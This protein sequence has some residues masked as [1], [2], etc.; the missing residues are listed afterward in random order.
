[1]VYKCF[2]DTERRHPKLDLVRDFVDPKAEEVSLARKG[3]YVK[4]KWV[5]SMLTDDRTCCM[6]AFLHIASEL[7]RL[8]NSGNCHG[9]IRVSNLILH[10]VNG[11][12]KPS[13]LTLILLE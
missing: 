10:S 1:M 3:C 12:E 5:G 6:L 13:W 9:D 7:Q 11:D 2:F 4:M 8:H